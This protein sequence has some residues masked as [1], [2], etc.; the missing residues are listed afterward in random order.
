MRDKL[1]TEGLDVVEIPRPTGRN[2]LIGA[3][4]ATEQALLLGADV[5]YQAALFDEPWFGYADFLV[6]VDGVPS[7]FGDYA[8]RGP[9]HQTGPQALGQRAGADEHY[10]S[11]LE[12]LQRLPAAA[13]GRLAGPGEEFTLGLRGRRSVP[14]GAPRRF[15]AFHADPGEDGVRAGPRVRAVP[16]GGALRGGVGPRRPAARPPAFPPPRT[17]LM[18]QGITTVQALASAA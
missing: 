2:G 3:A 1:V 4:R 11:I 13:A 9:R 16:V 18:E 12:R 8:L 17:L 14:R 5:V 7:A 6:R 10:G 15:L